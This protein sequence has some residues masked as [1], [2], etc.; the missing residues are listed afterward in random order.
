MLA[1]NHIWIDGEFVES[2]RDICGGAAEAARRW[3]SRCVSFRRLGRF[4]FVMSGGWPAS[5][6]RYKKGE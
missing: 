2:D 6:S 1:I 5:A 4:R 3:L